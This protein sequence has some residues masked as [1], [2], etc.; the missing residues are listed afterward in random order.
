MRPP[1]NAKISAASS[2][3]TPIRTPYINL[4]HGVPR[5]GMHCMPGVSYNAFSTTRRIPILRSTSSLARSRLAIAELASIDWAAAVAFKSIS[6]HN[7][8]VDCLSVF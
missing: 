5:H 3:I 4:M 8:H 6:V 7:M 1:F 2:L